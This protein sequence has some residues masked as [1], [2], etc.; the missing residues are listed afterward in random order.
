ML[1]SSSLC[2]K[3]SLWLKYEYKAILISL[4]RFH[5]TDTWKEP[6]APQLH[7]YSHTNDHKLMPLIDC[8]KKVF[9]FTAAL[10]SL[11]ETWKL[12]QAAR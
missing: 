7:I 3:P 8:K 10:S 6:L 11:V 1:A 4:Y 12:D 2:L 9:D 5:R